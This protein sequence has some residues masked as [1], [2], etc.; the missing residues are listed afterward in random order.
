MVNKCIN[1]A[2]KLMPSIDVDRVRTFLV[3]RSI[4][5][6]FTYQQSISCLISSMLQAMP[7]LLALSSPASLRFEFPGQACRP[8]LKHHPKEG[9]VISSLYDPNAW[10]EYTRGDLL[11]LWAHWMPHAPICIYCKEYLLRTSYRC[12]PKLYR[13][14]KTG[15]FTI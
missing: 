2:Q 4:I 5:Y 13:L 7:S 15:A 14:E 9:K 10:A 6:Q 11:P 8:T 12:L 1:S 3:G